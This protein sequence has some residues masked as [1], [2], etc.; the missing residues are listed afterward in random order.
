MKGSSKKVNYIEK[1]PE[2]SPAKVNHSHGKNNPYK[3]KILFGSIRSSKHSR[4]YTMGLSRG[5]AI[6]FIKKPNSDHQA[7]LNPILQYIRDN[8]SEY[9]ELDIHFI[10]RRAHFSKVGGYMSDGSSKVDY[11]GEKYPFTA[12]M[13]S[14]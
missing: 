1:S 5:V 14:F 13:R 4:V 12:F 3:R 9:K 11:F 8:E 6:A 7:F 10:G 2:K